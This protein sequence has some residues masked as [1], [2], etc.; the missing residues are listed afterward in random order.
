ML[1]TQNEEKTN[2]M[3]MLTVWL[4]LFY[5]QAV[6]PKQNDIIL[7]PTI[8]NSATLHYTAL[9]FKFCYVWQHCLQAATSG[10]AKQFGMRQHCNSIGRVFVRLAPFLH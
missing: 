7:L 1:E 6:L 10:V 3:I 2:R 8:K 4:E 9:C 5:L